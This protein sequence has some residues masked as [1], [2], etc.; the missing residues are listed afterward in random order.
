[1]K[2]ENAMQV[3]RDGELLIFN[4][5]EIGKK[6]VLDTAGLSEKIRAQA[7][8]HG[9]KQKCVDAAAIMR[10]PETGKSAT[11]R[12]KFEAIAAM[13]ERL[14]VENEWNSR[15][16]GEG[17]GALLAAMVQAFPGKTREMLKVVV[18]GLSEKE[19]R[20]LRDSEKLRPFLP[21]ADGK[22]GDSI[23]AGLLG[24]DSDS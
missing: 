7:M 3:V 2:R 10:D 18:N 5:G 13:V 20:A 16:N 14:S 11:A 24:E 15:E 17:G 12:Q 4:F 23:L 21:K 9:L 6:V 8:F 1:M 22:K 19:K